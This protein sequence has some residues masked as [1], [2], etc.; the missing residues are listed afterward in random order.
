MFFGEGVGGEDGG[1]GARVV[2]LGQILPGGV[3]R[4]SGSDR[5]KRGVF[6]PSE[7]PACK[8]FWAVP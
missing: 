5:R 8:A 7:I 4:S 6:H 3:R 2:C 1:K